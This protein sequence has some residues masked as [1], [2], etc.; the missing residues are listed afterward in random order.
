MK[1]ADIRNLT[2]EELLNKIEE[3]SRDLQRLKFAHFASPIENPMAIRNT[4]K[5]IA[6]MFTELTV[7]QNAAE[8]K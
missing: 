7:K 3:G 1:N 5:D 2:V 6:R 4:R 8:T